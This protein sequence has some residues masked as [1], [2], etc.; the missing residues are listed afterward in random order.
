MVFTN[1]TTQ[2]QPVLFSSLN[3]ALPHNPN[4]PNTLNNIQSS[5]S[6]PQSR[7]LQST[8]LSE[9]HAPNFREVFLNN[10]TTL[11]TAITPIIK[12]LATLYPSSVENNDHE[13]IDLQK[14]N[15]HF[16]TRD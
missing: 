10:L 14:S 6:N 11:K 8:S 3:P 2:S 12:K 7:N 13:T 9:H 16:S 15:L 1:R 4:S 5:S